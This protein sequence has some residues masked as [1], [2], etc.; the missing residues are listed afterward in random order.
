MSN[1]LNHGVVANALN[2]PSISAEVA[3]RLAPFIELA[4]HLG[5]FAGQLVARMVSAVE[6]EYVGNDVQSGKDSLTAAVL[7]GMMR[8]FFDGINMV[9]A[10]ARAKDAG[11]LISENSEAKKRGAYENYIRV[12]LKEGEESFS[13]AGT[14]FSDGKPRII[15]TSG[16]NMESEF[17]P[18]LLYIE[19]R[20]MPGFIGALGE[21]LGKA[22]VNIASLAL[23]RASPHG[24]AISIIEIDEPAREQALLDLQALDMV[25][26]VEAM[27][28]ANAIIRE[29]NF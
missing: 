11:I 17:A 18:Y 5:A 25:M 6:I 7:A 1:Y 10:P 22:G 9:S 28:F 27:N 4:D 23:G 3:P 8:R 14:V 15:Q 26:R 29:N 24:K 21:V 12:A 2:M 13:V 19:G 16:I 20:D